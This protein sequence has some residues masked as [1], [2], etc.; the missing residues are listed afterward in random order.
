M[1]ST[2][3]DSAIAGHFE[4]AKKELKS[5]RDSM[6]QEIKEKVEAAKRKTLARAG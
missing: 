5:Q 3:A 6:V 1:S 4:K 2:S